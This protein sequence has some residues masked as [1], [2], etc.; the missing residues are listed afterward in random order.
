MFI[1]ADIKTTFE[2][3]YFIDFGYEYDQF[4]YCPEGT[5]ANGYRQKVTH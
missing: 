1:S 3:D 2:P 5:W 4:A